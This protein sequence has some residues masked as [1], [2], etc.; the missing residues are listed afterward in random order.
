VSTE[1]FVSNVHLI[2]ESSKFPFPP[3]FPVKKS[4]PCY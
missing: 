2:L 4:H 3:I 1:S